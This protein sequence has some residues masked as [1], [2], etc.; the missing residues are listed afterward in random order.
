[1][2][3]LRTLC[4]AESTFDTTGKSWSVF[5]EPDEVT[6]AARRLYERAFFLED[7]SAIDTRE[8]LVAVYHF[9]HFDSPGRVAIHVIVPHEA[10]VIPSISPV[11]SGA[12][13]HERECHDFFGIRFTGHPD[14]SPLLVP[15]DLDY[16][17]LIKKEDATRSLDEL[18]D[19]GEIVDRDPAFELFPKG[20]PGEQ[21]G[22]KID[23][24]K[25]DPVHS[26][27]GVES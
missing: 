10:P 18:L 1:M 4:K 17:P 27:A 9:D 26:G 22:E 20:P 2:E 8:G 16:Y 25:T 11:F 5:V 23:P 6:A 15:D 24:L 21:A 13:W 14:L 19:P 3:G 7:I 12:L